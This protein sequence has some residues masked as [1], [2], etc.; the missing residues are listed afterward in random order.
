MLIIVT[1]VLAPTISSDEAFA[2]RENSKFNNTKSA[3]NAEQPYTQSSN[4]KFNNTKS[5]T[6]AERPFAQSSNS[7]FDNTKSATNSEL[8]F[9]PGDIIMGFKSGVTPKEIRDFYKDFYGKHQLVEKE[10]LSIDNKDDHQARLAWIPMK[11][12]QELI[13]TIKQDHR[14]KYAEFNYIVNIDKIPNDP[15]YD[16]LWGLN[17]VG[18][19]GG[20]IDADIDAPE[21]W[22]I[23]T[24]S[25]SIIIAVIDTGIDYNH[26]DL[27]SNIW[28]N[29]GET[30]IDAGGNDKRTNGIDDDGN[31]YI[32]DVH[33]INVITNSGD[34]MDDNYHGTHVS[35]IIGAQGNNGIGVVGVNW[36]VSIAS[37][38]FLD[39]SGSGFISDAVKCFKYFN[40]LKNE[41]GQNVLI[42]NNSW[43]GGGFSQSLKDAMNGLDQP[44][45]LPILHVAAA[46][47]DD[48]DT[49]TSPHYP[50]SY[51]LDNIISVA[52]TDH[53]DNYAS[54][55][56]YG[57]ISVDLAAPGVNTLST[58]LGNNYG[59][60]SGT[61]V[62]TP[63]VSGAAALF[64][65][66]FP[67]STASQVKSEILSE[68]DPLSDL[69]KNTQTNGRLNIFKTTTYTPPP[70][71]LT[72]PVITLVGSDPVNIA[73]G[74]IYNDAG[75]TAFDNYDGHITASIVT[76][77][78]PIDTNTLGTNT[79]TYDVTDSAGNAAI[80]VTRTV[81]VL[82]I[83]PP[84][85]TLTG[86]NP[87]TI[88][89]GAGYTELGATTD[90]GSPVIIDSTAFIDAVGS[91]S[92][93]YDSV[94]SSGNE[95]IQVIRTVDVEVIT[96]PIIT[97]TGANPQTI[98]FGSGYTE[99]GATTDDGSP[100]TIDSSAFIDAVGSYSILYDSTDGTNNAIQ[101]IRTV[102]VVDTIPPLITLTGANPQTI[103]FGDD[104]SCYVT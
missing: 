93:L 79:V 65:S 47:N 2:Q 9:V 95:A 77:G 101:V 37:C 87:Q 66:S 46:G 57:P 97:L 54:F 76:G 58:M 83:T 85:I 16:Q 100:V 70:P 88:E 59:F 71:D 50:S 3:T 56:N 80:Q 40:S 67:T 74:S 41:Y 60:D 81:N 64:W 82:D 42:T 45:M 6:N 104:L 7:K 68:V 32:D 89:L 10:R 21:A 22:D 53:N 27:A 36:D 25:S 23:S 72:P 4:S 19:T 28:N 15:Q 5:A 12:T 51:D 62:A 69:S 49:D 78:L 99:L 38:K 84:I 61:S 14:I 92:I 48:L 13:D 39:S 43:G 90:D 98:E 75:A 20:T 33:G 17:N 94:D 26:V 102:N 44:G 29:P 73:I 34:P 24:G 8:P 18:I 91:Y 86:D 63:H 55:S 11:V 35:G 31:G 1:L 30:G 52:A 96:P 103:E